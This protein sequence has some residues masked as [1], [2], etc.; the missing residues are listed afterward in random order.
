MK[1]TNFPA[2]RITL[3][4]VCV[5]LYVVMSMFLSITVGGFKLTFEHLPVILCAVV[6]GPVDGLIV[7][8]LGELIN[9][10]MTF[11]FT[12]TTILWMMPALFR[13]LSIG[14]A[15]KLLK[16][17]LGLDKKFPVVFLILCVVSGLICSGINTF[18]LYVDSKMFGYYS[19][20]LVFGALVIRLISSALSSTVM[21]LVTKPLANGLTRARI[22]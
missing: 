18:T 4:G 9:Q 19:Y 13:G 6:F 11:G 15:A 5:A 2:K 7:G 8:G 14:L 21:A 10:M 20:A 16:G 12:P 3:C 17:K 1:K 22:I